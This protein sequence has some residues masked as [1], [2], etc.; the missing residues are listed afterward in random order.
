VPEKPVTN[1]RILPALLRQN[2][3]VTRLMQK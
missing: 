2:V 3:V 1:I